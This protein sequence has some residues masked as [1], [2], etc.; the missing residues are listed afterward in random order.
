MCQVRNL[1]E[2]RKIGTRMSRMRLRKRII[3]PIKAIVIGI[4]VCVA[5]AGLEPALAVESVSVSCYV[6]NLYIG[7]VSVFNASTAASACNLLYYACKNE[8]SGCFTDFDYA[9][10]V[11][12]DTSGRMYLK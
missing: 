10:E 5:T 2:T 6:D 3:C 4:L 11:C 9:E 7:N 12:V 8:C 1:D